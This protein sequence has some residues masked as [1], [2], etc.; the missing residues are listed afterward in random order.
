MKHCRAVASADYPA[1]KLDKIDTQLKH[2]KKREHRV[3]LVFEYGGDEAL[4]KID[5]ASVKAERERLM[6][7]RASI[8][9]LLANR[10]E[11]EEQKRGMLVFC[12]LLKQKLG[13]VKDNLSS[14]SLA[15][16]RKA[17]EALRIRVTVDG[18]TVLIKGLI[19]SASANVAST[20]IGWG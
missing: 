14:F 13:L 4:L 20:P 1:Q 17:L 6:S 16:K 11:I 2:L 15:D 8:E 18:D 5:M 10:N 19:P 12:D 9:G 7:E 3:Y